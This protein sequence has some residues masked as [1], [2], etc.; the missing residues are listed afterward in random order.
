M[1]KFLQKN[2]IFST[3]KILDPNFFIKQAIPMSCTRK[4]RGLET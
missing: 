2:M 1:N 3:T 4:N